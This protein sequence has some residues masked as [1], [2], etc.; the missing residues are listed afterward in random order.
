MIKAVF[1]W[2]YWQTSPPCWTKARGWITWAQ[3]N[4]WRRFLGLYHRTVGN[5]QKALIRIFLYGEAYHQ[6]CIFSPIYNLQ[7]AFHTDWVRSLSYHDNNGNKNITNFPHI[8][9]WKTVVLHNLHV[10]FLFCTFRRRFVL[11][12]TWNDPF[13][14]AK[15]YKCFEKLYQTVG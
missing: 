4:W 11:S 10:H 8:W 9:Q 7:S 1:P 13:W 5:R 15:N 2:I 6:I 3:S 12:T 14:V